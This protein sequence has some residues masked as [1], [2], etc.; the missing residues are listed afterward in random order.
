[1][2]C[3]AVLV[4]E[5]FFQTRATEG[6]QTVEESQRLVEHFGANEADEFFLEIEQSGGW[7]DGRGCHRKECG[8]RTI[9]REGMHCC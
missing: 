2:A 7:Y 6:V 8:A 5:P 9:L 3:F 4:R 1:M